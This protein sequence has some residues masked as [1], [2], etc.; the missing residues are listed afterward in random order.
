LPALLI[1]DICLA[2]LT[3]KVT[4]EGILL[5]QCRLHKT[6]KHTQSPDDDWGSQ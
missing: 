5:Y 4:L 3:F 6:K 2:S 1:L